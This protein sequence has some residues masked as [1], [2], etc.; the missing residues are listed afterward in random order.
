MRVP[1]VNSCLAGPAI[2]EDSFTLCFDARKL[3]LDA[4]LIPFENIDMRFRPS[5]QS[6]AARVPLSPQSATQNRRV[7][8]KVNGP[9]LSGGRCGEC[10]RLI[11]SAT[12]EDGSNIP[13]SCTDVKASIQGIDALTRYAPE[14]QSWIDDR[15]DGTY[16]VQ[17][18]CSAP[19]R[20]NATVWV[21]GGRY[22]A[23][24]DVVTVV[25]GPPCP[26]STEMFGN[27]T[28]ACTTGRSAAFTIIARDVF[29]NLCSSGGAK[30][31]V[32]A[33]GRVS[34][35]DVVDNMDGTYA[36]EYLIRGLGESVIRLDVCLDGRPVKGSPLYPRLSPQPELSLSRAS[37][38]EN[39]D[40][41]DA[42]REPVGNSFR[43]PLRGAM[44]DSLRLGY[45]G[46]ALDYAAAASPMGNASD[47]PVRSGIY[48]S[49]ISGH[50]SNPSNR[51][52]PTVQQFSAEP[53][54]S[55]PLPSPTSEF[56]SVAR[57]PISPPMC[58]GAGV[59]D[60]D[61]PKRRTNP[62]GEYVLA[63]QSLF[64]AFASKVA[65]CVAGGPDIKQFCFQDFV[66]L[67]EAA[68]IKLAAAQLDIIFR[69]VMQR[70]GLAGVRGEASLPLKFFIELLA[71]TART[72]Y[73]DTRDNIVFRDFL[74]EH[75][76]PLAKRMRRLDFQ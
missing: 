44:P 30:F 55:E 47:S 22:R 43:S 33:G 52:S 25:P 36:V 51:V 76:M 14:P 46:A 16:V 45:P 10:L 6:V 62:K 61:E 32:R 13:Y 57:D 68:Q 49:S 28:S 26:Q 50:W 21:D 18:V 8:C 63:M 66:R 31:S 2:V 74:E 70:I 3:D 72:R 20:Y 7:C 64:T 67:A 24:S 9:A 27:G 71:E 35:H 19:G 40:V 69:V 54:S 38:A 37:W 5:P 4:V 11:V 53:L 42:I 59:S 73:G 41:S 56:G 39:L 29:G 65:G 60:I 75:L 17:F 34:L 1:L 48:V 58:A 12:R 15:H 23:P